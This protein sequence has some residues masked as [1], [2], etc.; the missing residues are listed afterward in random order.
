MFPSSRA[1]GSIAVAL[2]LAGCATSTQEARNA[3]RSDLRD[4]QNLANEIRVWRMGVP[5]SVP[6]SVT[7]SVEAFQE[8]AETLSD[9][10]A[11][12]P[13]D[14]LNGVDVKDVQQ[15]L[16]ELVD[17]SRDRLSVAG[18]DAKASVLDQFNTLAANL[19]RAA[20]RAAQSM[21]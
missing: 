14:A 19:E 9:Q 3:L 8:R 20:T 12:R 15:A 2:L 4:A 10:I 16:G 13:L 17:F 11:S 21:M 6:D 5:A 18:E 7:T 1:I